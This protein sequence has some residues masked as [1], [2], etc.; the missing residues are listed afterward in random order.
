MRMHLSKPRQHSK[1]HGAHQETSQHFAH[2]K[3]EKS[4]ASLRFMSVYDVY[5]GGLFGKI[6]F[7]NSS[8][9]SQ[10]IADASEKRHILLKYGDMK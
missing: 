10:L 5:L 3:P 7:L 2:L 1:C 8:R 6:S 9:L 4:K